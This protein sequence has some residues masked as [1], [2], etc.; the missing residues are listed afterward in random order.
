MIKIIIKNVGLVLMA[1]CFMFNNGIAQKGGKVMSS[2]KSKK[3]KTMDH[4]KHSDHGQKVNKTI[5]MD[6]IS[7]SLGVLM[8]QN[9][10]QMGLDH[11]NTQDMKLAMDDVFKGG[12]LSI[13][14]EKAQMLLQQKMAEINE[15][16]S[17]GSIAE[18]KKFLEENSKKPGIVT[19]PSGLQYEVIKAGTGV[20]PSLTDKV[21]THYEGRL[22]DGKIFDS[23]YKRGEPATFGVNQVIKGWT[24]ALQLMKEGDKWRLY[25]PQDL[26]YGE[27]GAGSDIPPYSALI[28]DV[29][30]LKVNP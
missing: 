11:I 27:R 13:D 14:K 17:A 7:Y 21:Q 20:S 4:S 12:A 9:I 10:Q 28:F 22:I 23:S 8:A 24:E 19:L 6:S 25:I 2:D 15:Q 16:K 18:G 1:I 26:A 30:L 29:E 3:D 5:S